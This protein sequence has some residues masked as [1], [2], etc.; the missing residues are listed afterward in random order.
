MRRL[1]SL[2][3]MLFVAVVFLAV[4]SASAVAVE[5][6]IEDM[7]I[8]PSL[9]TIYVDVSTIL[10]D[11]NDTAT[12]TISGYVPTRLTAD[13]DPSTQAATVTGIEF[14]DVPGKKFAIADFDLDVSIFFGAFTGYVDGRGVGGE[15][16]TPP[17]IPGTV[18]GTVFTGPQ[19]EA[20]MNQ[21]TLEYGY[22]GG[23][24]TTIDLVSFPETGTGTT[25][26]AITVGSPSIVGNQATYGV[27]LELPFYYSETT[28]E[29]DVDIF[30][31]MSGTVNA[32]G[33]FSRTLLPEVRS[34]NK[35][36]YPFEGM[37]LPGT[38]GVIPVS[39]KLIPA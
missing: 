9:L 13:F 8:Q 37:L 2:S 12:P 5:I 10:G 33:Q 29:N 3:L 24:P 30:L 26:G 38:D 32:V 39:V 28:I 4:P 15:F 16:N 19:H 18:S 11:D 25:D 17:P 27:T 14:Y 20:I 36:T 31:E 23:D 21:G 1:L 35:I 7:V 22:T 34:C 6:D